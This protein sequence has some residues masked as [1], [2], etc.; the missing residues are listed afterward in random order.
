[1]NELLFTPRLDADFFTND[2]I[3]LIQEAPPKRTLIGVTEMECLSFSQYI[4]FVDTKL[5]MALLHIIYCISALLGSEEMRG[6]NYIPIGKRAN[7]GRNDFEQFVRE[8]VAPEKAF[9]QEEAKIVQKRIIDFYLS[10]NENSSAFFLNKYTEIFTDAM[11]LI[12]CQQEARLKA[13]EGWPV[14]LYQTDYFNRKYY[15]EDIPIKGEF[16]DYNWP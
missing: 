9:G 14:Y 16:K 4:G 3:S 11:F 7:Y 10:E 6:G 2:P 5:P 8:I 1:M 12:P 13:T 15:P